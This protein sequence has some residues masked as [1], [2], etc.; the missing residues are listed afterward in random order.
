M[1]VKSGY[2]SIIGK[3]NVGKSTLMNALLGQK[4]SITNPK[5]QTTRKKI[6]GIYT[7]EEH[8]IV[9]VDTP[10]ILKPDYLLQEKMLEYI[11]HAVKDAD[12]ILVILDV[13]TGWCQPASLSAL[14][15]ARPWAVS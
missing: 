10:G 8:Q 7:D 6:L 9:F 5:P 15:Q 12:V 14:R 3:P 11:I 1:A 4:L 13:L 2:V